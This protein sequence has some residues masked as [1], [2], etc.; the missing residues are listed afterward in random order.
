MFRDDLAV[1]APADDSASARRSRFDRDCDCR[2]PE[3]LERYRRNGS[4]LLEHSSD[5]ALAVVARDEDEDSV[6][7]G[8]PAGDVQTVPP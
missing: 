5:L 1:V 2:R 3:F 8:V 4:K 7:H 6:R